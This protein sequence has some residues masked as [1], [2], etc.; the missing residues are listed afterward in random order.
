MVS[1]RHSKSSFNGPTRNR[2]LRRLAAFRSKE[3][4]RELEL[5]TFDMRRHGF[6]TET[7]VRKSF[8]ALWS[9]N[10]NFARLDQSRS[11]ISASW[12]TSTGPDDLQRL[13]GKRSCLL[14]N[15][16]PWLSVSVVMTTSIQA[17]TMDQH[18]KRYTGEPGAV[19][20]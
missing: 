19:K 14:G 11:T 20:V 1:T 15:E 10:A 17:N 12:Q 7:N 6:N 4:P 13:S 5:G 9:A 2:W 18:C 3:N 8:N 16:R